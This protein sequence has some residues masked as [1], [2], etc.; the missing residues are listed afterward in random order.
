[1]GL[2]WLPLHQRPGMGPSAEIRHTEENSLPVRI[3]TF[4]IQNDFCKPMLP[5]RALCANLWFQPA[6]DQD[7]QIIENPGQAV[8]TYGSNPANL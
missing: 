1:M 7:Y 6:S 5:K 2:A 8:Q 3:R 4:Y